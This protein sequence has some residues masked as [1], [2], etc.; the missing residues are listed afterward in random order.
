ME[1][2]GVPGKNHRLIA[3]VTGNFLTC[4]GR[5]SNSGSGERQ[6]A[7]CVNALNHAAPTHQTVINIDRKSLDVKNNP[8]PYCYNV[9]NPFLPTAQDVLTLS[10]EATFIKGRR[11]QRSLETF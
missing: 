11:T 7:V 1:E 4:P 2:I 8:L 5:D 9:E 3:Q 10:A 6:L